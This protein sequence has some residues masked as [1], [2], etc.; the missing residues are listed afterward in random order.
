MHRRRAVQKTANFGDA[1]IREDE[2]V[3]TTVSLSCNTARRPAT[4]GENGNLYD[5]DA[6]ISTDNPQPEGLTGPS[7]GG[8]VAS[9]ES[10]QFQAMEGRQ[11]SETPLPARART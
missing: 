5:Q 1:S 6:S 11:T 10:R 4:F 2:D 3:S 7:H 8:S 9:L